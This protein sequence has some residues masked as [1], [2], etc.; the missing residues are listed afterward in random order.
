MTGSSAGKVNIGIQLSLDDNGSVTVRDN[1]G[2]ALSSKYEK[3]LREQQGEFIHKWL[4]EQCENWNKGID[5]LLNLH[6]ETPRPD[7]RIVFEPVPFDEPQPEA[8][9]PGSAGIMG[10]IF[11]SKREAVDHQNQ[12]ATRDFERNMAQWRE[13]KA[14]HETNKLADVG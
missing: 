5:A 12:Q 13:A 9:K 1:Q 3:L 7:A 14:M 11:K 6:H 8:P 2:N 10:V 4:E